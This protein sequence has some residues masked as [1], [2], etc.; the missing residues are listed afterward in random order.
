MDFLRRLKK[1]YKQGRL[2]RAILAMLRWKWRSI[3]RR[4]ERPAEEEQRGSFWIRL[5]VMLLILTALNIGFY[6]FNVYRDAF[7]VTEAVLTERLS[8]P[9][10]D[11]E[12][13]V[14]AALDSLGASNRIQVAVKTEKS[15]N[16]DPQKVDLDKGHLNLVITAADGTRLEYT[17]QNDHLD[18]F[19][20]GQI[21]RFTLVLPEDI[22][23]LEAAEFQLT[24]M[25]TAAGTY[26]RWSCEWAQVSFLLGGE[27]TLLAKSDWAEPCLFSADSPS[28]SLVPMIDSNPQLKQ[29]RALYPYMLAFCEQGNQTAHLHEKK[30][31]A[32]KTLGMEH[33]DLIYLDVETVSLENQNTVLVNDAKDLDLPDTDQLNYDGTMTLRVRYLGETNEGFFIDY[34][35]DNPGKDDFE[36]GSSSTFAITMPEGYCAFDVVSMEL[37]VDDPDDAWA[38]RML[39]AY[40]KT[41]Y[42]TTLELAR[43][44]DTQLTAE[45]GT[46]LFY[47]DMIETEISA[48]VLDLNT[49]YKTP[50]I[51]KEKI[52]SSAFVD[53]TGVE[54]SMYFNEFDYYERQILFYRQLSGGIKD[55]TA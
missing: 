24:L 33:G 51:F 43:L 21:D 40:L 3:R 7:V 41:D 26:D 9:A 46:N 6:F 19:E 27:R 14:L 55:E 44:T 28:A 10:F 30:A 2:K 36:L 15:Y 34:L 18:S 48:V 23:V 47:R 37:F 53:M 32:L 17:L 49:A 4:N 31:K 45:R 35:L 13:P 20:S 50:S 39:R 5:G 52:E 54:Y 11:A 38:M 8:D 1:Y 16:L 25:P 12:K 22:S 29:A 42:G